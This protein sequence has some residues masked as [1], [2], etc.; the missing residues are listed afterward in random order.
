MGL[1][2]SAAVTKSVSHAC[3]LGSGGLLAICFVGVSLQPLVYSPC[4][5]VCVQIFPFYK[6]IRHI[7]SGSTLLERD[8]ILTDDVCS[9]PISKE[10]HVLRSSGV[11]VST[12]GF[13]RA[14]V[15]P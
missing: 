9:D 6:D 12:Y 10:G 15:N 8:A 3:P 5:P 4:V 11:R 1:N 2:P 14:Q 13:G 7:G